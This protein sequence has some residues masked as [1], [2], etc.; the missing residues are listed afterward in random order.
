MGKFS[1]PTDSACTAALGKCAKCETPVL[2]AAGWIHSGGVTA[3][4]SVA[5]TES[6][7]EAAVARQPI[8]VAIEA[9]Q[10]VFQLYKSGVLGDDACGQNLD[11]AVLA[12]GY[13]VEGD[14]KYWKVKNSWSASWGEEGYIRQ[15]RGVESGFGECGIRHMASFPT[16]APA[17]V[18]V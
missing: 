6:A 12:V 14:K 4:S 13:G 10:R 11:H 9:D 16:V 18:V 5:T 8:S 15:A 17:T 3:Y 2:K 1:D 7:L